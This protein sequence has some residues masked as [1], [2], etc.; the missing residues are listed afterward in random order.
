MVARQNKT[1]IRPSA[2][3]LNKKFEHCVLTPD[4]E[5]TFLEGRNY[6]VLQVPYF[7]GQEYQ[8]QLLN[9]PG[10]LNKAKRNIEQ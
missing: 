6:S 5:C 7:C 4:P 8:C 3:W 2:Y 1:K 10:A 9:D